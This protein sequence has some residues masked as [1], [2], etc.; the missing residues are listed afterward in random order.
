MGH[1]RLL[2]TTFGVI[3][4]SLIAGACRAELH[5][6]D[7]QT[8]YAVA[9]QARQQRQTPLLV[10]VTLDGCHF[11]HK[12]MRETY[13]DQS[14]ATTIRNHW[15]PT[16]IDGTQNQELAKKFGVRIFPTTFLISAD[17]RVVDRIE[18]YMPP[19]TFRKRVALLGARL[20]RR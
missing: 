5:S 13:A 2:I 18:G 3:I 15:L 9:Q 11:C 17:N 8:D 14:V 16:K 19:E 12:M 1:R 4:A 7:W 10:F 6:L 20:S